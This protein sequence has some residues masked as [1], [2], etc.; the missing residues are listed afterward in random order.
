M[1][2]HAWTDAED[3]TLLTTVD[4]LREVLPRSVRF[5][6]AVVGSLAPALVV[7][8]DAARCRW[9]KVARAR[10]VTAA[11]AE[12]P[13]DEDGWTKAIAKMEEYEE[14]NLDRI[15]AALAGIRDDLANLTGRLAGIEAEQVRLR[16]LWE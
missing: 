12:R 4:K 7:T 16:K 2:R 11:E 9:D 15:I 6:S 10:A 8:A 3:E 13:A 1:S 5:W 14:D